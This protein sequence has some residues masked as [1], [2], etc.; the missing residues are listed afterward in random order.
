MH[1]E[2]IT[3]KATRGIKTTFVFKS[4]S[5]ISSLFST[6]L[7]VKIL[8]EKDY[9]VYNIFYSIISVISVFASFGIS[10]VLVRFLP[11]YYAK[12]EYILANKLLKHSSIIRMLTNLIVLLIILVFWSYFGG[13]FKI[14]EL[15]SQF[16]V[17]SLIILLHFQQGILIVGFDSKFLQ[18]YS[19]G[20]LSLFS[21]IKLCGYIAASFFDYSLWFVLFVDLICYIIVQLV[22]R[23]LNEKYLNKNVG[24][25]KSFS[26]VEKKRI[27]KY[28]FFYNFN[29]MGTNIL[30]P[31]FDNFILVY[32]LDLAQVGAYSFFTRIQKIINS[33]LPIHYFSNVIRPAFFSIHPLEQNKKINEYFQFMVKLNWLIY[34]P[35]LFLIGTMGKEFMNI[36]LN[37]KYIDY[38]NVL[39]I[40]LLFDAI[41]AFQE[42]L[43]FVVQLFEKVNIVLYSKIFA[44][45]N[46]IADIFFIQMFGLLGAALATGTAI[47][48]KNLYIFYFSK[49]S[50]N[51]SELMSN[52][53]I[54]IM[55]W[56]IPFI[57]I[58]VL[59][60]AGANYFILSL[61]SL[62]MCIF[63]FIVTLKIS[64]K[65]D[66]EKRIFVDFS[67]N[68]Y[69]Q[70]TVQLIG[71]K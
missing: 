64:I 4:I 53:L 56:I 39:L 13:L 61:L 58:K 1:S 32:Y 54:L 9:G 37:G 44:L 66:F 23:I 17:F 59:I 69:F 35:I 46:I 3:Q 49:D 60:I 62:I 71:Y 16:L 19:Q 51:S 63:L 29:D 43:G 24:K 34:I 70:K 47:L 52:L 14:L 40:I 25:L 18:K 5:Q 31:N 41:I 6:L 38:F 26:S 10:N 55:I 65:K 20:V 33:V 45:Y 67:K 15:K 7:L 57:I 21:F 2:N 68:K 50:I 28:A 42:P 48:F 22:L 36:Y 27:Y 30:G 8:N 11:E 12:N